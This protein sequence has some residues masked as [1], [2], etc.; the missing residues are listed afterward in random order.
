M[1]SL[2]GNIHVWTSVV[3]R[4][5]LGPPVCQCCP[6]LG[7]SLLFLWCCFLIPF[8][9]MVD[10]NLFCVVGLIL[11]K[12]LHTQSY[13]K[14]RLEWFFLCRENMNKQNNI[15]IRGMK[16]EISCKLL[17][18]DGSTCVELSQFVFAGL[19]FHDSLGGSR[20]KVLCFMCW[21]LAQGPTCDLV[22]LI[23]WWIAWLT[24]WL[25]LQMHIC[26]IPMFY[27]VFFMKHVYGGN[28]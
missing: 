1:R 16:S 4:S 2:K 7:A 17:T 3:H 27:C 9:V 11:A 13:I 5:Q 20:W 18:M 6:F 15:A 23:E 14:S 28:T 8:C 25:M 24:G 19:W 22:W 12:E 10:L 21:S 26:T